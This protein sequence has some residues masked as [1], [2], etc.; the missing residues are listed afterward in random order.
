MKVE[1]INKPM[2]CWDDDEPQAKEYHVLAKVTECSTTYP[3]KCIYSKNTVSGH[4]E[5]EGSRMFRFKNV[6]PISEEVL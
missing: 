6:K 2:L 4:P 5:W 1:I 3:Y